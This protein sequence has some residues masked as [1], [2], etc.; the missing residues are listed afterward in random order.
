MKYFNIK[1]YKFSTILKNIGTIR[2]N[3]FKIFKSVDFD[4]YNLR[5]I[6]KYLNIRKFHFT[7]ITK[8]ISSICDGR[9]IWGGDETI[10]QVRKFWIPERAV[11]L[12][13]SDRYSLSIIN[14]NVLKKKT[15]EAIFFTLTK[16]N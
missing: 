7:E 1:R 12:T 16:P 10:N 6:Y 2:Q 3:F 5:K 9:V 4:R 11:E 13:F 8:N 15:N 14:L